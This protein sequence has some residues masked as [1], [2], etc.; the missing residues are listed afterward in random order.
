MN[1]KGFTL[2]EVIITIVMVSIAAGL[3]L[4][5]FETGFMR[6]GDSLGTL[7][8]NYQLLTAIEIVNAD[9]RA[10][11]ESNPAQAMGRYI[12]GNLAGTITELSGVRAAVRGEAISFSAPDANRRVNEIGTP[13]GL[14]V[15][16]TARSNDSRLVTILGN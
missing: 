9:Y 14:Y 16:I 12:G 6:S 4:T 15:K 2:I 1:Q 11:L 5:F 7:D 10:R 13:G 3:I 8:D